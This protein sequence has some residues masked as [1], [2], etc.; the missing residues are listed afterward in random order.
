[1]IVVDANVFLRALTEPQESYNRWMYDEATELF[2]QAARDE[3]QLV[4]SSAVIAEVAFLLTSRNMYSYDV[5][6]SVQRLGTVLNIQSLHLDRKA[7]VLRALQLWAERPSMGF[8]DALVV[9]MAESMDASLA[10]FDTGLRRF[11]QIERHPWRS[12]P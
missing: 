12:K 11:T 3:V 8:V 9:A 7:D 10:S 4:T 6:E 1:M 5:K 2:R